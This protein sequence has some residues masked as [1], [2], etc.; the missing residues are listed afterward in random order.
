MVYA[1]RRCRKLQMG[2]IQWT[3][4]LSKIRHSI[5]VWQLVH[6]RLQGRKVKTRTILRKKIKAGM[7]D[8]YTDVPK[9]F[10]ILQVRAE[11]KKYKEYRLNAETKRQTFQ[12]G[13]AQARA[14]EGKT[15]IVKEIERMK[16]VEAQRHSARRI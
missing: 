2:A 14:A 11:Y 1:E 7:K 9:S 10:A 8:T 13:L 4:E 16:R 5:E 12:E 3:P 15:S 6:K